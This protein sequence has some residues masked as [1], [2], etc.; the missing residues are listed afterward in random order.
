MFSLSVIPMMTSSG[1]TSGHV[2]NSEKMLR[3]PC[4]LLYRDCFTYLKY[5]TLIFIALCINF[6][7]V[8]HG[9]IFKEF[10]NI[11]KFAFFEKSMILQKKMHSYVSN[12][13]SN[14]KLSKTGYNKKLHLISIGSHQTSDWIRSNNA[15]KATQSWFFFSFCVCLSVFL[16]AC[17]VL[18]FHKLLFMK[19]KEK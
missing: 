8:L 5:L 14:R 12:V 19:H 11:E 16:L 10:Q 6:V 2:T 4:I 1:H 18:Y 15:H 3:L 17:F 9:Q 13:G 7:S